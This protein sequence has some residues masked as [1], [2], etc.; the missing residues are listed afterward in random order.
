MAT[1][2]EYVF[3]VAM[4]LS[5]EVEDTGLF[6]DSDYDNYKVRAPYILTML[7]AELLQRGNTF[8]TYSLDEDDEPFSS[9]DGSE[10]Y[11]RVTLP[12]DFSTI[13]EVKWEDDDGKFYP[14]YYRT[15]GHSTL[16]VAPI[17]RGD[18]YITYR[19]IPTAITALTD[20][21]TV[22]DVTAR[23]V[24]PYGLAAELFKEEKYDLYPVLYQRYLQLKK[25]MSIKPAR[26]TDTIDVYG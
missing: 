20:N 22:D 24:L 18:M 3:Q 13:D 2:A 23:T 5:D 9:A 7:E 15:E 6:T 16:L 10:E 19:P 8:T 14:V 17:T 4:S 11:V 21:M 1:T 25:D 12:S 26:F